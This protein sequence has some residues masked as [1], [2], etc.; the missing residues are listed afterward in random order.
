[1]PKPSCIWC[2]ANK[3]MEPARESA[4]RLDNS[5]FVIE[6]SAA[7]QSTPVSRY[8]Q[9]EP[10][11]LVR[12]ADGAI[13]ALADRCP[14][15]GVP[16]SH[17]RLGPKG[18]MCRYHGWS[19]DRRGHC[20]HIPGAPQDSLDDIRVQS[21]RIQEL[22]G[23]VWIS[24]SATADLPHCVAAAR[25]GE[26]SIFL[27]ETKY[28]QPAAQLRMRLIEPY[29]SDGAVVQVLLRAPLGCSARITLCITPETLVTSRVFAAARI[30]SRWLPLWIAQ[31]LIRRRLSA[32]A[33]PQVLL[34]GDL[35]V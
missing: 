23:Q 24:L 31:L 2:R 33:H 18:L 15:Q 32:R 16:L 27:W 35:P 30:E 22:D 5:W 13:L 25:A 4:Q 8:I 9:D 26:P 34:G 11:V 17:G 7:I 14:H 21:Y 1:M 20:T 12:T 19:F 10:V 28:R 3:R 29:V 6:R